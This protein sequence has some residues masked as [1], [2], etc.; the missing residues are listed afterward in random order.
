MKDRHPVAGGAAWSMAVLVRQCDAC[1]LCPV[2]TPRVLKAL[3]FH[4]KVSTFPENLRAARRALELNGTLGRGQGG[5]GS[6]TEGEGGPR[7][8]GLL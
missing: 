6:G 4:P 3:L 1:V 8:S 7:G 5:S 2:S